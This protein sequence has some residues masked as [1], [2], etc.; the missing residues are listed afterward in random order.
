MYKLV[1]GERYKQSEERNMPEENQRRLHGGGDIYRELNI[2]KRISASR[3]V[4]SVQAFTGL[5]GGCLALGTEPCSV[6][7]LDSV[8]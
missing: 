6:Q 8:V 2:S 5:T 4:G 1:S 7:A 3:E